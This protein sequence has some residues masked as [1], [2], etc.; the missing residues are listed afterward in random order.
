MVPTTHGSDQGK[1]MQDTVKNG[2]KDLRPGDMIIWRTTLNNKI[3]HVISIVLVIA[4]RD[5]EIHYMS[6]SD[7]V[8]FGYYIAPIMGC[9]EVISGKKH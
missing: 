8:V 6:L 7:P 2:Y 9:T 1:T 4:T 3:H 5:K